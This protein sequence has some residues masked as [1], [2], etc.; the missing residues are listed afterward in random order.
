MGC[1][2]CRVERRS[3]EQLV[4]GRLE[5]HGQALDPAAIA[6]RDTLLAETLRQRGNRV[7]TNGQKSR[8]AIIVFDADDTVLAQIAPGLDLDQF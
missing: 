2:G 8:P 3:Q 5:P 1:W 4:G 7:V 6:S